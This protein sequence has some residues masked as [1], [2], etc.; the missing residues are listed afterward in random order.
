M[1]QF[2]MIGINFKEGCYQKY[3]VEK[4]ILDP[5]HRKFSQVKKNN[6]NLIKN[7]MLMAK[8]ISSRP[9]CKEEVLNSS[10]QGKSRVQERVQEM[11]IGLFC[12]LKSET[13]W[14]PKTLL[15]S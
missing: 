6:N 11:G 8:T 3:K 15:F 1:N 5:K 12:K 13:R 9:N 4:I 14:M 7:Q 10:T 2:H